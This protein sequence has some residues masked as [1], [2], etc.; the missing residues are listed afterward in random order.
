[1]HVWR[2]VIQSSAL[3]VARQELQVSMLSF[4]LWLRGSGSL[5][6][7]HITHPWAIDCIKVSTW[8]PN[9]ILTGV[10][11]IDILTEARCRTVTWGLQNFKNF[12]HPDPHHRS[13]IRSWI[14]IQACVS[15]KPDFSLVS[16][17]YFSLLRP[18]VSCPELDHWILSLL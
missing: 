18:I 5:F 7:P 4:L 14:C 9:L 8:G 3:V 15:L 10:L 11:V 1:M 2:W 6:S 13:S 12:K 16:L 17:N